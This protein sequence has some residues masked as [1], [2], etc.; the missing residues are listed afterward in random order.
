MARGWRHDLTPDMLRDVHRERVRRRGDFVKPNLLCVSVIETIFLNK[1]INNIRLV[2]STLVAF[3]GKHIL[4]HLITS[5][6]PLIF[7]LL[8]YNIVTYYS[9]QTSEII[10]NIRPTRSLPRAKTEVKARHDMYLRLDKLNNEQNYL[11][12]GGCQELTDDAKIPNDNT[13][14][15]TDWISRVDHSRNTSAQCIWSCGASIPHCNRK[16][17]HAI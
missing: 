4:S 10:W 5:L 2:F 1:G 9:R 14:I 11:F 13:H 6:W 16:Q 12:R 17:N 8:R 15:D 3:P 7:H